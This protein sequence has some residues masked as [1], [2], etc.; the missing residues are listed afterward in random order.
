M[1]S[2]MSELESEPLQSKTQSPREVGFVRFQ[3][4]KLYFYQK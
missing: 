1:V 2:I 4:K 3:N